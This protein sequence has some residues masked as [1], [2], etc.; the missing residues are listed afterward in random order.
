MF[1]HLCFKMASSNRAKPATSRKANTDADPQQPSPDFVEKIMS[2]IES[3]GTKIDTQTTALRQE[4][5]SVRQE[6]HTTVSPLQSANTENA[7]RIDDLEQSTSEWSSTVVSLESTVK[8]LQAEV[9]RLSDKCLDLEGRSRRQNIRLVGIEEGK[10]G[11]N[12]RRFSATVLKEMLDLDDTPRLDRA[13]RSLA[14]KPPPGEKPRPFII[15]VHHEDV[16]E[17]I[18]RISAQKKKLF[19]EERRVYIFPDFTADV[20][21]RRA[22]F[23][24]AKELLKDLKGVKFGMRFP[25]TL[26]ITFA[27]VENSF[28][29]PAEAI[30]YIEENILPHTEVS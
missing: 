20:S 5:T 4:I 14:E 19:Y 28:T 3:L 6:L 1:P 16:K 8:R 10:E 2:A 24:E 12:A 27:E 29:V 9:Q 21:K 23:K 13:H 18:L 11:N 30:S 25:A 15:R 17:D 7:K 26:R 22:A